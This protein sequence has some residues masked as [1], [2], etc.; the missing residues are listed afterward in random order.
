M[1]AVCNVTQFD[2]CTMLSACTEVANPDVVIYIPSIVTA[3]LV[4]WPDAF[5]EPYGYIQDPNPADPFN[6]RTI[7]YPVSG[8]YTRDLFMCDVASSL[9]DCWPQGYYCNDD[10]DTEEGTGRCESCWL[11]ACGNAT[12]QETTRCCELPGGGERTFG[13]P[14]VH[15]L[16]IRGLSAVCGRKW[17]KLPGTCAL[18]HRQLPF[19]GRHRALRFVLARAF[20]I[21]FHSANQ[22]L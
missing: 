7:I 1:I 11:V 5:G 16:V 4:V 20:E 21:I 2:D 8:R 12:E 22:T 10:Y 3:N 6:S 15:S 9:T 19:G 17:D 14:F 13:F 18:L